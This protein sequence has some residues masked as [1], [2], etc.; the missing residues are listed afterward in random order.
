MEAVTKRTLFTLIS[1]ILLSSMTSYA[2]NLALGK[3]DLVLLPCTLK[4]ETTPCDQQ[5]TQFGGVNQLNDQITQNKQQT[6]PTMSSQFEQPGVTQQV[7]PLSANLPLTSIQASSLPLQQQ[8]L[9]SNLRL[10]K[11][12]DLVQ[13]L[14][15]I[16]QPSLIETD[17]PEDNEFE[18]TPSISPPPPPPTTQLPLTLPLMTIPLCP[19]N[20]VSIAAARLCPVVGVQ[21]TDTTTFNSI[22][23]ALPSSY[24]SPLRTTT[25]LE[26]PIEQQNY[27]NPF[28]ANGVSQTLIPRSTNSINKI[29]SLNKNNLFLPTSKTT[30]FNFANSRLYSPFNNIPNINGNIKSIRSMGRITQ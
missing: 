15:E 8:S 18:A 21:S 6:V 4:I 19:K 11:L 24:D 27:L 29:P 16:Q 22:Q 9:F 28:A 13:I 17:E 3:T 12:A 14:P 7:I 23:P 25:F 1:S 20:W 5:G 26:N 30:N 2:Q 10:T